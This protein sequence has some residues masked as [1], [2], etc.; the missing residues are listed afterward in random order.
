MSDAI[1]SVG[2]Q[3]LDLHE[4]HNAESFDFTKLTAINT[5]P[6][7]GIIRYGRHLAMPKVHAGSRS[8]ALEIGK[9][10]HDAFAAIRVAQL[11]Q[12]HTDHARHHAVRIYGKDRSESILAV[13][14]NA[15]SIEQSIR[16]AAL[17]AVATS[18]FTDDPYDRR[19]TVAN[20][21]A[22]VTAYASGY[23]YDRWPVWIADRRDPRGAIGI[24]QP[25]NML[26]TALM[27]SGDTVDIR[28]TG[29]IDALHW[30]REEGGEVLVH[31][32]KTGGRLDDTWAQSFDISH[33][34]TGYTVA[35][36]LLTGEP[37][38]RVVVR[39]V[40]LPLPKMIVNGLV[41][42]WV[43]REKY[44][45]ERWIQWVLHTYQLYQQ[46]K[47]TPL[48]A[49]KYSHSCSRYFRPCPFV[50]LCYAPDSEQQSMLDT[51]MVHDEWSP[52]TEE[53]DT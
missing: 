49:P 4:G 21:E 50:P 43:V 9:A 27:E 22:S 20:L 35:G 47:Q 36:M 51:E 14:R 37:I 44:H 52:L 40:Q 6:T 17:E 41:D 16:H 10:A 25:Y 45:Q 18:G 13:I 39:G 19:R 38:T 48:H 5:C 11:W 12:P 42:K 24:E 31:E 53:Y 46:Y 1:R 29:K 26:F 30:H 33:Q 23:D 28:M 34:V 8:M 3:L 2:F 15:E 7:W 32:N